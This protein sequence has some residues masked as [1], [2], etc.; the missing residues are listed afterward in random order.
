MWKLHDLSRRATSF[1][2]YPQASCIDLVNDEMF[3]L[4][5]AITLTMLLQRG[6]EQPRDLVSEGI[7]AENILDLISK[8]FKTGSKT[9]I[10]NAH[11]QNKTGSTKTEN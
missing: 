3:S 2:I 7:T 4:C 8:L 11:F 9:P 6:S 10:M 1:D 5:A